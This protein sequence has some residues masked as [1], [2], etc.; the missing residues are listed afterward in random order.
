MSTLTKINA[1]TWMHVWATGFQHLTFTSDAR[2]K[3]W[4]EVNDC[5]YSDS[6]KKAGTK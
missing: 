1:D 4:A 3:R 5:T 6:T 2:A